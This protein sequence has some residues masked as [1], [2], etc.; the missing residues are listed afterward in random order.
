MHRGRLTRQH[1]RDIQRER[2]VRNVPGHPALPC[3]IVDN[4]FIGYEEG[5]FEVSR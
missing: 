5:A 4:R 2:I 3:F 1:P